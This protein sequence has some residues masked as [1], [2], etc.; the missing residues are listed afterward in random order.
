M[1]QGLEGRFGEDFFVVVLNSFN[2]MSAIFLIE[3]SI[4]FQ[5]CD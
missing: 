3:R 5:E 4:Q 2:N 1:D